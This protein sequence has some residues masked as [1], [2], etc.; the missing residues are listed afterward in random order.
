MRQRTEIRQRQK[1]E[2]NARFSAAVQILQMPVSELAEEIRAT[3]DSNPLLEEYGTSDSQSTEFGED[4]STTASPTSNADLSQ[5]LDYAA[6]IAE[7]QTVR[8]HLSQQLWTAGLSKARR[9]IAEAIIDSVDERGYLTESVNDIQ[10]IVALSTTVT[11]QEITEVLHIVQQFGPPGIAARDLTE[12][13]LLQLEISSAPADIIANARRILL[14]CFSELSERKMDQIGVSLEIDVSAVNA[15]IALIQ[16]L[17]P[18]PGNQFGTAAEVIVPDIIT[19]KVGNKWQ[20][21]LNSLVL[22]KLRIS[23]H[24]RNMIDR[25]ENDEGRTYLRKNLSNANTFLDNVNR[26]HETVLSVAREIVKHQHAFLEVGEAGMQ[27]LKIS[28]IAQ[29]L[30]L[31]DSTVS[32]ACSRKY[33]MTPRGTYEL[34]RLF[35]VRIP[36]RFGNDESAQAIKHRIASLVEQEDTNSPLSDQQI[37]EQLLRGGASLSRRTVAKYRAQLGIPAHNIRKRI[38]INQP[39]GEVV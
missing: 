4:L 5:G 16:S 31:H 30:N 18:Y 9:T 13:L 3:L 7:V 25:L 1:Q 39:K 17:N 37:N 23:S 38:K 24:Y 10:Q 11:Q 12:C 27:P 26:R 22:P 20:V 8:K 21:E 19:R 14:E 33:I 29:S 36:N 35:S 2:F 28:E 6:Q 32:R 15:A 34:K